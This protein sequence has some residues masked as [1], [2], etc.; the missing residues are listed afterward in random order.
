MGLDFIRDTK[1]PFEQKRDKSKIQEL[2]VADLLSYGKP[3]EFIPLFRC[4]LTDLDSALVVG[5]FLV[6][7]AFSE[8]EV[9]IMQRGRIIG[10][11]LSEDA[12]ELTRLMKINHRYLGIITFVTEQEAGLDGVFVVK[13]KQRFKRRE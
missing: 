12:A 4:Q 6:G 9:V 11:M 10:H 1:K 3:D 5:L 13:S 2:D 8:T 7:R